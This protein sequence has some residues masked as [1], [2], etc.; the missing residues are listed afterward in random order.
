MSVKRL[1][2]TMLVGGV[3]TLPA[4]FAQDES[5][6][7]SEVVVQATGSFVHATEENGVRQS[8]TNSGGVLGTYRWYF[9]HN[10]GVEFDYGWSRNTQKFELGGTS[11][12]FKTNVHEA[13]A[14]YV[15]RFPMRR[16]TP[17]ALAGAGT[18]VFDRE[19]N[20]SA[21]AR[22]AFVYGAGVDWSLTS[23]AFLR[24]QYR[25]QVY[26]APDFELSALN[27]AGRI[28]HRVQPSVGFGFRF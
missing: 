22:P 25:G 9:H 23:R 19:N 26:N 14:A 18:L 10:H 20:A 16:L 12:G 8:A 28:T 13:T 27:T 24:A 2:V 1:V 3:M 11:A 17:F 5:E 21:Q 15:L 7:K 4:A 6:H